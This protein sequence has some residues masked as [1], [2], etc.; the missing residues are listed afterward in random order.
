M[1][2]NYAAIGCGVPEVGMMLVNALRLNSVT[3]KIEPI[4][5]TSEIKSV[6]RLQEQT[7]LV[8]TRNSTYLYFNRWVDDKREPDGF[9]YLDDLNEYGVM[10]GEVDYVPKSRS[11]TS[12]RIMTGIATEP[13]RRITV[14]AEEC[15]RVK[16]NRDVYYLKTKNK[17]YIVLVSRK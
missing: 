4:N 16:G 12:L 6:K 8:K 11:D 5:Y 1:S 15:A 7:W 2:N 10:I 3:C 17:L 14:N 9:R 13:I